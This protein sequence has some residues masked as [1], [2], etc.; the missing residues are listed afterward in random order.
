MLP[1][2][3][4]FE[5]DRRQLGRWLRSAREHSALTV[6]DVGAA[7]GL[8]YS[9]ISK[10]ERGCVAASVDSLTRLC[11]V[12]GL[13]PGLLVEYCSFI[14]VGIYKAAFFNDPDVKLRASA[15][16]SMDSQIRQRMSDFLAGTALAVS[17]LTKS[18]NPPFLIEHLRFSDVRQLNKFRAFAKTLSPALDPESRRSILRAII[19]GG[20]ACLKETGLVDDE[21][22]EAYL[23]SAEKISVEAYRPW[24]PMPDFPLSWGH[25]RQKSPQRRDVEIAIAHQDP[26][27]LGKKVD[28]N[29]QVSVDMFA[30]PFT[31]PGVSSESGYWK[32]LVDSLV[33]LTVERGA[34][35]QLARDVGVSRQAVNHWISGKGAPSA[36]LTL[37]LLAWATKRAQKLKN[38][39]SA[40]NTS[41][42]RIGPRKG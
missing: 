22:V 11:F 29:C 36:E 14:S 3:E 31:M 18:S 19:A 33:A 1:L 12:L 34:K 15:K 28:T 38:P 16:G 2:G 26:A 25:L 5:I 39:G 37:K 6:R 41:R 4:E 7:S 17:Y 10:I 8:G 35:S 20:Y 24:I 13:P 32:S 42:E 27:A 30:E 23:S 9:H 40:T 21:M